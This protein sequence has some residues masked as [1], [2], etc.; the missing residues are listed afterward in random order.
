M[1][2]HATC[3]PH[4]LHNGVIKKIS[5]AE[6][7]GH[8]HAVQSVASIAQRANQIM[9]A[10]RNVLTAELRIVAGGPPADFDAQSTLILDNFVF[11][12]QECT[13][14]ESAADGLFAPRRGCTARA[15]A[16]GFKRY[17]NSNKCSERPVHYCDGCCL[18]SSGTTTRAQQIDHFISALLGVGLFCGSSWVAS[19][20]KS[21]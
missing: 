20:S 13:R 21:R 19:P 16:E 5:E 7:V 4:T 2:E 17:E 14:S 3:A 9:G 12:K 11:R 18:D 15:G 1:N 6:F 8:L 10:L